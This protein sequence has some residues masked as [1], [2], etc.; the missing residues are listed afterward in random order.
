M[1]F[2]RQLAQTKK[3]VCIILILYFPFLF[4][5][6]HKTLIW[7][8]IFGTTVSLV[9]ISQLGYRLRK[10]PELS[11]HRA[12]TYMKIGYGL[13]FVLI[14]LSLFLAFKHPEYL[15]LK[16][17]ALGIFVAPFI[18]IGRYWYTFIRENYFFK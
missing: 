1:E 17:T 14:I 7:G 2:E 9:N 11:M 15:N 13:R 18:A 16:T 4:T 8:L 6:I 10:L 5:S 3:F 12:I